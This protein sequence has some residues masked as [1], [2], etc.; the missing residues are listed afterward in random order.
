MKCLSFY[1]EMQGSKFT[2]RISNITDLTAIMHEITNGI[3]IL[4]KTVLS[5][6]DMTPGPFHCY[7]LQFETFVVKS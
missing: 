5:P 2:F 3:K 1:F 4:I 7:E 6:G